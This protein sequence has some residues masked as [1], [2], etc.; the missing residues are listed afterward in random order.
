MILPMHFS[1][2]T[3][4]LHRPG[5]KAL[6]TG[7]C[8]AESREQVLETA[9]L[10]ASFFPDAI[11]RA[12]TWKPRTRPGNFEGK[13]ED[14]LRWLSE[15]KA[16]TGLRTA[17]E[18][19]TPAHA[20]L[21]MRYGIDI[22]WVGARTTGNPFMVEELASSLEGVD[23]PVMV[24]NPLHPDLELWIGGIERLA[25]HGIKRLAAV[26][27]GF[28]MFGTSEYRNFPRWEIVYKLK[29]LY[30]ELPV[31][32]DVSHIA[33]S[34]ALIPMLIQHATDINLDG[35]MVETHCDPANALSDPDQQ[36]SPSALSDILN[37]I[38]PKQREFSEEI[39]R[40]RLDAI[41]DKIDKLDD[42]LFQTLASRMDLAREIGE[43]KREHN[44]SIL[45]LERWK[46]I[47]ESAMQKADISGNNRDFIRNIFLQIH[48]EAIRLQSEIIAS[49]NAEK[50]DHGSKA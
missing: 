15:V 19:A 13:G 3:S 7:P 46:E 35:L 48:D 27:R 2:D 30:P 39:M 4:W 45:Q 21:A 44:V 37:G 9:R 25:S 50:R 29:S 12:G 36:I 28:F 6:I 38:Q 11:F 42:T 1:D 22:L 17:T 14:A 24:K 33:G 10:I 16:A 43:L 41:R 32:C 40:T 26:H 20:E 47:I 23:I 18:V 34:P 8:S 31:I 49:E 5:A